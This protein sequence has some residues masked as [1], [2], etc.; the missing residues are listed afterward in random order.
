MLTC[1]QIA[2]FALLSTLAA[3]LT[4]IAAAS[5]LFIPG[6]YSLPTPSLTIGAYAQDVIALPVAAILL[7]A[8]YCAWQGSLRALLVWT[9]CLGYLIYGYLLYCFDEVL[10]PLYPAYIAI[11]GLS[12]YSMIGL[13]GQLDAEAFH[14]RIAAGMPARLIAVVLAI[15]L[16]LIPPWLSFVMASAAGRQVIGILS[17]TVIDL[18]FVIP[19]YLLT[20][21]LVWRR[22]I[23]GFVFAGVLLVKVTTMGVSLTIGTLWIY[24]ALGTPIDWIQLPVYVAFAFMGGV[25]AVRYLRHI[26]GTTRD[27]SPPAAA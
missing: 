16:I 21:V 13:L 12:L 1:K 8:I 27:S 4:F 6:F 2:P 26:D 22:K 20:A 17:V 7:A 15:P 10:T 19:A 3:L 18:S 14:Q 24:F 23:W 5:G 25:T 9:G 11:L